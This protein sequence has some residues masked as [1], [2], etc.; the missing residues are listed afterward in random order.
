MIHKCVPSDQNKNEREDEKTGVADVLRDEETDNTAMKE[1]AQD[2]L[3]S[4]ECK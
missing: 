2:S 4:L 3:N 1:T